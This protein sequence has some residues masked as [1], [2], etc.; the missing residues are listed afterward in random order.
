MKLMTFATCLGVTSWYNIVDVSIGA[1]LGN[2]DHCYVRCELL[3]KQV[4]PEHNVRSVVHLKHRTHCDSVR[5]AVRGLAC[6]ISLNIE[7]TATVSV[8]Q[9][10]DQLGILLAFT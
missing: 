1:P 5:G 8:V 7:P 3:V 10:E 9:S 2:S 4:V 6:R